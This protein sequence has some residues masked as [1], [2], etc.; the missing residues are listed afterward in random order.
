M[1]HNWGI[2]STAGIA[3]VVTE[4]IRYAN[5]E[6]PLA[7][8]SRSLDKA[9]KFAAEKGIK[10]AY[11]SLLEMA[12]DPDIDIV[13]IAT[14][15]SL[16]YEQSLFFLQHNKSVLCEKA[17]TQN[18]KE[19]RVLIDEAQKRGL[20]FME[21][22]WTKC[23]PSFLQGL[24]WVKE[25]RIGQIELFKADFCTNLVCFDPRHRLFAN[26]LGGGALLD[27]GSYAFHFVCAFMG[28]E[29][30]E[31]R[32]KVHIGPTN[33]DFDSVTELT[34]GD[35]SAYVTL[36]FD[37]EGKNVANIIGTKGSIWFDSNFPHTPHLKL[38]DENNR[39]VEDLT[40]SFSHNGYEYEIIEAQHSL[41][42]KLTSSEKIPVTDSL[43]VMELMDEIRRRWGVTFVNELK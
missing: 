29:P 36:G 26:E 40:L 9:K 18:A 23:L 3:G 2:V 41:D 7:V 17:V 27:I 42:K 21:A 14:P 35:A 4:A 20:L 32:T 31:I 16:H 34:Y 6:P 39:V 33:V 8:C 12:N 43:R 13:Y 28:Y 25:G 15:M 24:Q 19:L 22:M 5:G 10:R 1:K 37:M 30:D 38:K 11:G